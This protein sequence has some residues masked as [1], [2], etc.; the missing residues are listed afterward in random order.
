MCVSRRP[1]DG[2]DGDDEEDAV[3]EHEQHG[4][5]VEVQTLDT[6][7]L[8]PPLHPGGHLRGVRQPALVPAHPGQREVEAW[9]AEAEAEAAPLLEAEV[10][11][12]GEAEGEEAGAA[13]AHTRVHHELQTGG[14]APG[15]LGQPIRGQCW[16]KVI[17]ADQSEDSIHLGPEECPAQVEAHHRHPAEHGQGEEV[18]QVT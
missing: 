13:P 18:A 8:L 10:V 1:V 6:A 15:N 17:S 2:G 7:L 5:Q 3:D 9:P 12:G 16:D 11:Q 4:G 14:A